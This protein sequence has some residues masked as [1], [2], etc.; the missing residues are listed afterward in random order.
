MIYASVLAV[1]LTTPSV[2]ITVSSF[3]WNLKAVLRYVKLPHPTLP[4]IPRIKGAETPK[5]TRLGRGTEDLVV[6]PR[7][8]QTAVA[9]SLPQAFFTVES[10]LFV[11]LLSLLNQS[12]DY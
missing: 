7:R 3:K 11:Y 9:S 8:R 10:G 2:S 4:L 12:H 1:V 6:A 5:A